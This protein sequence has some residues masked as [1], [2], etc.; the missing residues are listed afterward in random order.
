MSAIAKVPHDLSEERESALHSISEKWGGNLAAYL[1]ALARAKEAQEAARDDKDCV[2][3]TVF[4]SR[5]SRRR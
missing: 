1:A 4:L 2:R 5:L 3:T